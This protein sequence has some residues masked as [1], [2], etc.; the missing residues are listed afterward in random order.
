MLRLSV[1]AA[2]LSI[3]LTSCSSE[4]L[5]GADELPT[6]QVLALETVEARLK[7]S[8]DGGGY[9]VLQMRIEPNDAFTLS[10]SLVRFMGY[11]QS[12]AVAL[13]EERTGTLTSQ[14]AVNA[15]R[16]LAALRPLELSPEWPFA[17]VEDCPGTTSH[18]DNILVVE[19]SKGKQEGGVFLLERGCASKQAAKAMQVVN[20]VRSGLPI[21]IGFPDLSGSP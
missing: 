6:D 15:R 7:T 18:P 11:G 21:Q 1:L 9:R 14:G 17:F 3:A 2:A 8:H 16:R 13:E 20:D 12:P 19:F 10:R 5:V 4:S